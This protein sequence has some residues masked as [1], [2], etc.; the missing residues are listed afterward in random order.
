MIKVEGNPQTGRIT[1]TKDGEPLYSVTPE[2]VPNLT[3][4]LICASI[5]VKSG[6]TY[7]VKD[8]NPAVTTH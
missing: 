1:I 8:G 7:P 5:A 6:Y 4:Q 2:E 3:A